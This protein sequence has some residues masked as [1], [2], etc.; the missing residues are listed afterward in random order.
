MNLIDLAQ[1]P[2]LVT[3]PLEVNTTLAN[4]LIQVLC[5]RTRNNPLLYTKANDSALNLV[6]WIGQQLF[7]GTVPE[8]LLGKRL[9]TINPLLLTETLPPVQFEALLAELI[10]ESISSKAIAFIANINLIRSSLGFGNIQPEL[11]RGRLQIL[12]T[13]KY[14]VESDYRQVDSDWAFRRFQG[15]SLIHI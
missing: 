6:H 4:R 9:L 8:V 1:P 14:N 7:A 3:T 13:A 2:A 11:A 5:R 10:A 15:L 12:A